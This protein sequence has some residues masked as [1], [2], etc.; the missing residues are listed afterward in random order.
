LTNIKKGEIFDEG[1]LMRHRKTKQWIIGQSKKDI[2][3]QEV[4]GCS[5][6]PRVIDLKKKVIWNC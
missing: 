3:A 5:E 4:G 1:I 6:G 2:D